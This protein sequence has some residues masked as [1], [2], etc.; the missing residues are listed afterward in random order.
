MLLAALGLTISYRTGLVSIG[1]EGQIIGGLFTVLVGIYLG[2][3]W[4]ILTP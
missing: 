3:Y 1:A 2:F 4:F